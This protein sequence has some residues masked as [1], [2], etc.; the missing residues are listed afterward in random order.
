MVEYH[1]FTG[2]LIVK[3]VLQISYCIEYP[4]HLPVWHQ[5][6]CK[7]YALYRKLVNYQQT[8]GRLEPRLPTKVLDSYKIP[9]KM[10]E[11]LGIMYEEKIGEL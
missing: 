7:S 9:E 1:F 6:W 5:R 10:N 4:E 3:I 11:V 2:S 8:K